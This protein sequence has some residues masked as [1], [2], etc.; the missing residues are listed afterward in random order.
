MTEIR[1]MWEG[2][3]LREWSAERAKTGMISYATGGY[4]GCYVCDKCQQPAAGLYRDKNSNH[5]HCKACH[6]KRKIS[7]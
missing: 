7:R 5:W 1:R 6:P 3:P 4:V 2:G